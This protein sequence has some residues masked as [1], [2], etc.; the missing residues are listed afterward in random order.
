MHRNQGKKYKNDCMESNEKNPK[1]NDP[2]KFYSPGGKEMP[3]RIRG[4]FWNH[5]HVLIYVSS[6]SVLENKMWFHDCVVEKTLK[7]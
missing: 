2:E 3:W 6:Q 5:K 7:T 1:W 4:H